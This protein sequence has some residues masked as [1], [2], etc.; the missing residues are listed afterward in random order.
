MSALRH[1]LGKLE[2]RAA[3]SGWEWD[4]RLSLQDALLVR[5]EARSV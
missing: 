5:L 1:E 3:A 4:A 2:D